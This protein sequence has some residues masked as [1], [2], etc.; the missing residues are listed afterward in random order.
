MDVLVNIGMDRPPIGLGDIRWVQKEHGV[1]EVRHALRQG[2]TGELTYCA[3]LVVPDLEVLG[4]V[5]EGLGQ[6]CIAVWEL[7]EGKGVLVGPRAQAWGEFRV[8]LFTMLEEQDLHLHE[9]GVLEE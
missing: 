2:Q 8:E 3:Q 6:D 7:R 9:L 4:K 1:R 5:S